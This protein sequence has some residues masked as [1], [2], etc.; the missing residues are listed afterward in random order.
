MLNIK[1]ND[2]NWNIADILQSYVSA[3][4]IIWQ[5]IMDSDNKRSDMDTNSGDEIFKICEWL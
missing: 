3:V 5:Q 4:V 2:Q 1:K